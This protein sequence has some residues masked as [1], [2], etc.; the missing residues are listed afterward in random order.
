MSGRIEVINSRKEETSKWS[1]N[2]SMSFRESGVDI[3]LDLQAKTLVYSFDEIELDELWVNG[4]PRY[5]KTFLITNI[6][7]DTSWHSFS[8]GIANIDEILDI[9]GV[10]S[11]TD[12]YTYPCM[13][14]RVSTNKGITIQVGKTDIQYVQNWLEQPDKMYITIKYT[15]TTDL[16]KE[17]P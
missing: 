1:K 14:Y 8:H 4:K 16:A 17:A 5:Q 3:E 2:E 10:I 15:K 11:N 6:L 13:S 9:S 12:G 7:N